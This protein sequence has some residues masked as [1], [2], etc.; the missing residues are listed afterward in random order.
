MTGVAALERADARFVKRA[1]ACAAVLVLTSAAIAGAD[2]ND[3]R[4]VSTWMGKRAKAASLPAQLPIMAALVESG[5]RNLPPS[6]ADCAGFFQ[7]RVSLWDQGKYAGFPT[8][9]E[10][11]MKWFI[12][13]AL[14]VRAA[15]VAAGDITFGRDPATWG[16]WAAEVLRPARH[17]RGLY[18]LRLREAGTLAEGRCRTS[19]RSLAMAPG[20]ETVVAFDESVQR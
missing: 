10:V 20:R 18:Q 4:R 5:L 7:M 15:R 11:Q 13:H 8:D 2:C 9:P 3:H 1:V 14:A 6:A 19:R 12:D 16:E 17:L